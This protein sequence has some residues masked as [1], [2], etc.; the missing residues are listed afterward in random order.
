MKG[1]VDLIEKQV[2]HAFVVSKKG[3]LERMIV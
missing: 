3:C 2:L 1:E